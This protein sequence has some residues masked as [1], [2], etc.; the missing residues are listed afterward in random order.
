MEVDYSMFTSP[1][2]LL[3]GWTCDCAYWVRVSFN[4]MWRLRDMI[5]NSTNMVYLR[6]T[7]R[8]M[9]EIFRSEVRAGSHVAAD[10]LGL[11][12]SSFADLKPCL[13]S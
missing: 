7:R 5:K 2:I 11:L 1:H 8:Y 9:N 10:V 3:F 6:G 13:Q 4:V 12:P